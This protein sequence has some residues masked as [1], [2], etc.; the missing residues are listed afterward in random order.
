MVIKHSARVCL[1]MM[2]TVA[3]TMMMVVMIYLSGNR[4][5]VGKLSQ[6]YVILSA[7]S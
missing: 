3:M 7:S 2:M 6:R 1:M 4:S 5:Q